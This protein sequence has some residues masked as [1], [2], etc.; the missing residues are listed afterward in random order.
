MTHLEVAVVND[1]VLEILNLGLSLIQLALVFLEQLDEA[2]VLCE[3]LLSFM[4]P[5]V[6]FSKALFEGRSLLVQ[7]P[8]LLLLVTKRIDRLIELMFCIPTNEKTGH[9]GDA[10][11]SEPLLASTEK[12]NQKQQK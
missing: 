2:P 4:S 5:R 6:T 1:S 9:F 12:L 10:Q 11:S 8:R 3:L 7:Q